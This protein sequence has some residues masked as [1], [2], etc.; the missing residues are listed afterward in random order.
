[1][2]MLMDELA[3]RRHVTSVNRPLL[4]IDPFADP[5]VDPPI[6]R[7]FSFLGPTILLRPLTSRCA[8]HGAL[9]IQLAV[10]HYRSLQAAGH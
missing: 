7:P 9:Y 6:V 8:S 2:D 10:Y 5:L 4:S 1:M 3:L